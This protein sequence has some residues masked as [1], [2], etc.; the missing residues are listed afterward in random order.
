[1]DRRSGRRGVTGEAK[2]IEVGLL[3]VP[4][5]PLMAFSAL[6]EPLR[7]ANLILGHQAYRWR[8]VTPNGDHV[9]TSSGVSVQADLRAGEALDF[10]RVFVVSGGTAEVFEAPRAWSWLRQLDRHGVALGA[11]ADGSFFLARA[12]LLGD[13]AC[14]IHWQSQAAFAEAFPEIDL[15]P[16]LYVIDRRRLTSAG[17]IGAF[18]M[19]LDLIEREISAEVALEVSKWFVHGRLRGGGDR[20]ALALRLRTGI[21]D[22]L[23]L[24]AIAIMERSFESPLPMVDLAARLSVSRDTLERRFR[25]VTGLA[26]SQYM[27]RLRLERAR[28]LLRHSAMKIGDIALACGFSDPA[29][30]SEVFRRHEKETPRAHRARFRG[31]LRQIS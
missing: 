17:G 4:G 21:A 7:A 29:Y 15:R 12:G 5:F 10:A 30:F 14:T 9:A 31:D 2:P 11:V 22:E 16:D 18:D 19:T 3:V 6:I 23:V 20:A 28:D 27:R 25:G 13:H 1:M 26:P 8:I 24:E